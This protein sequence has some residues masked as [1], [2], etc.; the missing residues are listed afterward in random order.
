LIGANTELIKGAAVFDVAA[1]LMTL[2]SENEWD[3]RHV[4]E[5]QDEMHHV[6]RVAKTLT[7]MTLCGIWGSTEDVGFLSL[8]HFRVAIENL[9]G[10]KVADDGEIIPENGGSENNSGKDKI[11]KVKFSTAQLVRAGL[12]GTYSLST[13]V[14]A[15]TLGKTAGVA[16]FTVATPLGIVLGVAY[17]IAMT[18]AERGRTKAR[19]ERERIIGVEMMRIVFV[20]HQLAKDM[21]SA[22][23]S[24][25]E[26]TLDFL[27]DRKMK[28]SQVLDRMRAKVLDETTIVERAEFLRAEAEAENSGKSHAAVFHHFMGLGWPTVQGLL[29]GGLDEA[30]MKYFNEALN[31]WW[32]A[33]KLP[34]DDRNVSHGSGHGNYLE[35]ASVPMIKTY[36][37]FTD[38]STLSIKS[39]FP[40]GESVAVKVNGRWQEQPSGV[41]GEMLAEVTMFTAMNR[42]NGY[43]SQGSTVW[44][45]TLRRRDGQRQMLRGII[46]LVQ[47][48]ELIVRKENEMYQE[49]LLMVLKVC[50]DSSEHHLACEDSNVVIEQM[51][52]VRKKFEYNV[53]NDLDRS[54]NKETQDRD[55]KNVKEAEVQDARWRELKKK[56]KTELETK[57]EDI[58]EV[59]ERINTIKKHVLRVDCVVKMKDESK[60]K[61]EIEKTIEGFGASEEQERIESDAKIVS[62]N[63]SRREEQRKLWENKRDDAQRRLDQHDGEQTIGKKMWAAIW[64]NPYGDKEDW[65][66]LSEEQLRHIRNTRDLVEERNRSLQNRTLMI[67]LFV[68]TIN[69]YQESGIR[70]GD[71]EG[72]PTPYILTM[73]GFKNVVH[74]VVNHLAKQALRG[75]DNPK[76]D[77]WK[78]KDVGPF[79]SRDDVNG[80]KKSLKDFA[81]TQTGV[82]VDDR[83]GTPRAFWSHIFSAGTQKRAISSA[84]PVGSTRQTGQVC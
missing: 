35:L 31:L 29:N 55:P 6:E 24:R 26:Q 63:N 3:N 79:F 84:T 17:F 33:F 83:V 11:E 12:G 39:G 73:P 74:H 37:N 71:C 45:E 7:E 59:R 16:G 43:G 66:L 1:E 48:S 69:K 27:K 19:D 75:E 62:E 57:E 9:T 64:N 58:A 78:C 36:T 5:L 32:T 65:G 54:L 20:V 18:R 72:I 23:K 61:E 44:K 42:I 22:V 56:V 40:A 2:D 53:Q 47:V 41:G 77:T 21:M 34:L 51:E 28:G 67:R 50:R 10:I 25:R 80:L 81:K 68:D 46:S 14:G 4:D 30:N 15:S 52:A 70:K 76:V 13:W 49:F 60:S 82:E 8:R 38:F